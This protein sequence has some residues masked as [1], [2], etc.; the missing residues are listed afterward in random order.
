MKQSVKVKS[1]KS[2][3]TICSKCRGEFAH[4]SQKE[5]QNRVLKKFGTIANNCVHGEGGIERC[6]YSK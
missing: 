2:E 1:L 4:L 3:S 5:R 6:P